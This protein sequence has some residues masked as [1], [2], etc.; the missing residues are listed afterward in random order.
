MILHRTKEQQG[1]ANAAFTLA[2]IMVSMAILLIVIAIALS[3]QMYGLRM[4][5][6]VKPKLSANEDARRAVGRLVQEV[7]CA[8][9]IRLGNGSFT[10]FAEIAANLPQSGNAIQVYP[11][12]DTN[13]FVR[14]YR[15][16]ADQKLKAMT[17]GAAAPIVLAQAISNQVVFTSEDFTGRVLTNNQNNRVIGLNLEFYQIQYPKTAVGPGNFYDYYQ[18]RTKITRRTLM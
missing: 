18:L 6:F 5:E 9:L 10:N 4:F 13:A 17:N 3:C 2:E 12:S 7:R 15:D 1:Q 16:A 14:Y 8:N 11:T